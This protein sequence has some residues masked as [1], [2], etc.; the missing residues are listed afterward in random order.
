M[1]TY[2]LVKELLNDGGKAAYL[3]VT[4]N[5]DQTFGAV[6]LD[7]M[8]AWYIHVFAEAGAPH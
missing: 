8:L 1:D 2:P 6:R 5:F 4:V 3:P 7:S